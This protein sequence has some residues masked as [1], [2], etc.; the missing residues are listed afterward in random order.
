MRTL[1]FHGTQIHFID[2][3]PVCLTSAQREHKFERTFTYGRRSIIL[4]LPVPLCY[5][6]HKDMTTRTSAQR[7]CERLSPLAGGIAGLTIGGSLFRYWS[8]TSQG[9]TLLNIAVA[10]LVAIAFAVTL[11]A[12]LLFWIVPLFASP[13]SKAVLRSVRMTR[14]DPSRDIM[15]LTF[16][17]DTIAELT[18][19]A[20]LIILV[21]DRQDL[22]AYRI[23]GH[24]VDHDIRY[25]GRIKT[26]VLLDHEPT[27]REARALLQPVVDVV[28]VQQLGEGT[29]YDLSIL[30]IEEFR[31][32]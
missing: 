23:H 24:L 4:S 3:C 29:F 31:L 14:Y 2:A 20:N 28:M 11:W 19:R 17:N 25:I 22:R 16:T 12:I 10:L 15:E 18:A 21:P 26:E 30:T 13:A 27:E 32:A 5:R 9:S 1:Q 7:W 6:H 8:L